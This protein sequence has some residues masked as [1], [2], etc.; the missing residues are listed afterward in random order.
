ML[1]RCRDLCHVLKL[2]FKCLQFWSFRYCMYPQ[3]YRWC[4]HTATPTSQTPA[5]WYRLLATCGSVVADLWSS[6]GGES[7]DS[8]VWGDERQSKHVHT[9]PHRCILLHSHVH[10]VECAACGPLP[11][12]DTHQAGL[13][14]EWCKWHSASNMYRSYCSLTVHQIGLEVDWCKKG[15]VHS[16]VLVILQY[17]STPCRSWR[18]VM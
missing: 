7:G 6:A 9:L 8:A 2:V 15:G 16:G 4:H 10:W 5:V 3:R 11:A 12:V 13:E 14:R 1:L 17:N 18:E